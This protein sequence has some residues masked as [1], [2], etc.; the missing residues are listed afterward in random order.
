M[1]GWKLNIK[2]RYGKCTILRS[3]GTCI[4]HTYIHTTCT[5]ARAS[6]VRR[7]KFCALKLYSPCLYDFCMIHTIVSTYAASEL[8]HTEGLN[9]SVKLLHLLIGCIQ[10]GSHS[11]EEPGG[12]ASIQVCWG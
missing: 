10:D 3:V 2:L 7:F 9:Y 1:M 8:I 6:P 4:V 12:S 11:P 5:T